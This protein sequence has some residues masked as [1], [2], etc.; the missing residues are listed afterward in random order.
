MMDTASQLIIDFELV[1]VTQASSSVGMEKLGFQTL[2]HRLQTAKLNI[3]TIITDRSPQ[4]K[5]LMKK[6]YAN[7][8]H[9]F[10]IWH[11]VKI[12]SKKIRK[13]SKKKGCQILLEWLPAISNHLWWSASSC[14]GD[15]VLLREKWTSI[16][17][18]IVNRH[19]WGGATKFTQCAHRPLSRT[20]QRKK[21]WL[22]AGST[23]FAALEAII[24]DK[25]LL[26]DMAHITGFHHT[27]NVEVYHSVMTKYCPKREHFDF[28]AMTLCVPVHSLRYLIITA[29]LGANKQQHVPE[30]CDIPARIPSKGGS[31]WLAKSMPRRAMFIY[32]RFSMTANLRLKDG[33]NYRLCLK[34]TCLRPLQR[35]TH[36]TLSI[37]FRNW[38][39]VWRN[40]LVVS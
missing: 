13:A 7:I 9:Q 12:V 11:F 20:E 37:S 34:E 24:E 40:E 26:K 18:H 22:E 38:F 16:L 2:M 30:S 8:N 35:L 4:V 27:G 6:A 39:P 19:M 21:K 15:V 10:D 25:T 36:L 28:D 3:A 17:Y 29:M 23:A 32:T 5:A 31:G 14:N 1:Q 33:W